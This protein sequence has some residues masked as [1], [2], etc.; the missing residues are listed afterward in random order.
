[1]FTYEY[2]VNDAVVLKA[3]SKNLYPEALVSGLGGQTAVFELFRCTVDTEFPI[4]SFSFTEMP[5][6]CG[7]VVSHATYLTEQTRHSG[8]SDSF[9]GLKEALA[10]ELGYSLM[11][12]TTIMTLPASVGNMIKSKYKIDNVFVNK[13]TGNNIGLGIKKL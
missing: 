9:R 11:L 8:L 1:M 13:R 7:I 4:G 5:G 10:K 3:K 2:K 6:C 12:A